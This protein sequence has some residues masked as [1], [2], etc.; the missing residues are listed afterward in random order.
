MGYMKQKKMVFLFLVTILSTPLFAQTLDYPVIV[1]ELP[2]LNDYSLFA[3]SGWDGNWYVGYNNCWIAQLPAIT[4]GKYKKA[5]I[6]IKLGRM[7]TVFIPGLPTWIRESVS[8]EIWV[9]I[10]STASWNKSC[11]YLLTSTEDIPWDGDPQNALDRTGEAQW[12]WTEI[13]VDKV[14]LNGDNFI[15]VWSTTARL[16]SIVTA[17]VIAAGWGNNNVNTW[18]NS[19]ISGEPPTNPTKA[20]VQPVTVFEPAIAL[21]LI[22][23]NVY[24]LEVSIAK[25]QPHP[26]LTATQVVTLS[27]RS[28]N[29]Q[30]TWLEVTKDGREWTRC[31][32]YI[33][34][35]PY[36]FT[37]QA[38]D[39]PTGTLK[40]RGVAKDIWEN[41]GYSPIL[42]LN[43]TKELS[44][45]LRN[46]SDRK[47]IQTID[48]WNKEIILSVVGGKPKNMYYE[49]SLNKKTW[50]PVYDAV[51]FSQ[52]W[53]FKLN[54][55]RKLPTN[56]KEFYLRFVAIDKWNDK[57]LSPEITVTKVEPKN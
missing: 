26:T 11:S 46:L 12:F 5:C 40:I 41:Y 49:I 47:D 55:L 2:N 10:N 27:I 8:G 38:S 25:V 32:S 36:I 23:E 42:E 16:N 20:L 22:P 6:G 13:P 7:K 28:A 24:S 48:D 21:K 44:I 34:K 52:P 45:I 43:A 17:P 39:L 29:V 15:V 9:A 31:S 3:T 57:G 30:Q 54:K 56:K 35:N 50:D 53:V 1:S 19:D 33:Y 51:E 37:I 18:I 4:P 14:N